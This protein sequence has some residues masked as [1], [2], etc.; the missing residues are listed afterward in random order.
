[1]PRI[2]TCGSPGKRTEFAYEGSIDNGV[3]L[4]F[5]SGNVKVS[6]ELLKAAIVQFKGNEIRGGFCMT[7]PTRGGLGEWVMNKSKILNKTSLTPRHGSFI[8]A[9]L[10]EE[11]YL[12]CTLNGNAV[13]LKFNA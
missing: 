13:L 9:I 12:K 7:S 5:A 4:K 10:Q 8:A 3:I 11:G 2:F 1:M 6:P